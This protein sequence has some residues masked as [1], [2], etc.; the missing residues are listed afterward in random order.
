MCINV[1]KGL[2]KGTGAVSGVIARDASGK[3]QVPL[4]TSARGAAAAGE[5]EQQTLESERSFFRGTVIN[6]S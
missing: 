1:I 2:T 5:E 6:K 3:T 4:V